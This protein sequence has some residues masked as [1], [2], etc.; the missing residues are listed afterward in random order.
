V[1]AAELLVAAERLGVTFVPG[2]DFFPRGGGGRSAARLAFSFA[3]PAHLADAGA[4]LASLLSASAVDLR[5]E[6]AA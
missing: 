1:D 3:S 4:R 6:H 2:P 5:E